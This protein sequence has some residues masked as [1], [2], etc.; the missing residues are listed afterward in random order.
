MKTKKRRRVGGGC[1]EGCEGC[2]LGIVNCDLS[3]G[4]AGRNVNEKKVSRRK[5]RRKKVMNYEKKKKTK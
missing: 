3:G 1:G 5:R 2:K 4:E